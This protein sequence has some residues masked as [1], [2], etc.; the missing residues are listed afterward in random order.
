LRTNRERCREWILVYRAPLS[1]FFVV[2]GRTVP[3]GHNNTLSVPD[4]AQLSLSEF[5]SAGPRWL[6]FL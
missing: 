5:W 2:P 1:W 3:L 4:R 6:G